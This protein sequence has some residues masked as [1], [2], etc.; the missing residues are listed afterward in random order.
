MRFYLIDESPSIISILKT[1][2]QEQSLGQVCGSTVDPLDALEDLERTKPDIVIV[3]LL[4]PKMDGITF[5]KNAK[6]ILSDAIYIMLSQVSSKE[7]IAA[8]YESGV[9]AYIQKPV[10]SIE[11]GHILRKVVTSMKM[12]RTIMQMQELVGHMDPIS[13]IGES[14]EHTPLHKQAEIRE[15]AEDVLRKIGILGE[16]G[17]R[18]I[19]AVVGYLSEYPE[20]IVLPL[21]KLCAKVG[22]TPKTVE[23]RMRRAAYAGLTSLA[24]LGVE[25]YANDIFT[26]YAGSLY[27]FE[28]V[29][30]EMDYIR[31]R[32]DHHGKVQI[33]TFLSALLSYSTRKEYIIV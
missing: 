19:V 25:D 27:Q 18:D 6:E 29:R 15:R 17:S 32:S 16:S 21:D 14:V 20:D 22:E 13:P 31:G 5:V 33:R 30:K 4:M 1:I 2:I 9:D 8:A 10:N 28:Q 23:Q 3:D 7:R 26:E 24:S 12:M 11:I